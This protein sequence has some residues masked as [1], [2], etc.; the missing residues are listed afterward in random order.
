MSMRSNKSK[1]GGAA[2]AKSSSAPRKDRAWLQEGDE[3][4]VDFLDPSV[5]KKVLGKSMLQASIVCSMVDNV[6][7]W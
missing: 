4:I 2:G 6:V 3:E 1:R 5:S 7:L